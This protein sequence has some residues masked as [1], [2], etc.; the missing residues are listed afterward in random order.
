MKIKY[1]HNEIYSNN[2]LKID[3]FNEEYYK[4]TQFKNKVR[5]SG[6]EEENNSSSYYNSSEPVEPEE[7][8]RQSLSRTKRKIFEYALCNDFEY[9][10]T[11]TFDRNKID[12]SDIDN[13]KKK[14]GQWLNNNIKRKNHNLKYI[15]I[16]ELHSD[17]KHFHLHGLIS[18]ITDI[19][20]FRKR[21]DV[22]RYNWIGWH[23]KFGFT[24]LEKIKDRNAVSNYIT[25][26]ITK[27]LINTF[28]RQRY[29]VSKGLNR[30][31]KIFEI[32][33]Y[34]IPINADYENEYVRIKIEDNLFDMVDTIT[35]IRKE[36]GLDDS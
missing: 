10:C 29:L 9:F 6:F 16:P 14:V 25:K 26:Y 3:E 20:E 36:C 8:L 18:G 32:D 30:P 35:R 1:I 21:G 22:M 23:N 7:I 33:N 27:D 4:V 13:L 24:S 15:L 11:L 5:K 28:N 2:Y 19:K 31:R 17:K 12:S 34:T